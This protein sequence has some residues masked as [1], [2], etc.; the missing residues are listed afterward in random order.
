MLNSNQ[1]AKLS[2]L[3]EKKLIILL[4]L[5]KENTQSEK[6]RNKINLQEAV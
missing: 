5:E 2:L 3:I 6:V 1:Y 4:D